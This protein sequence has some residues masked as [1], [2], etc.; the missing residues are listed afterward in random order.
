MADERLASHNAALFHVD[1]QEGLDT[2]VRDIATLGL[3]HNVVGLTK[4]ALALG[5]PV[6]VTTTAESM[7]DPM[8]PELAAVL[9]THKVIE[10]TTVNAWADPRVVQVSVWLFQPSLHYA[11]GYTSDAVIYASAWFLTDSG[12]PWCRSYGAS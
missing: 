4:A 1:H 7:W 8:I 3:K 9:P 10:R 2:G 11:D 6:V 12:G 5:I